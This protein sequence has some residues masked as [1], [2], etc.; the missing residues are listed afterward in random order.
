MGSGVCY[1]S[2]QEH[3]LPLLLY[4]YIQVFNTMLLFNLKPLYY[5]DVNICENVT[6]VLKLAYA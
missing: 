4:G 6:F 2:A 5:E 1:L 3:Y